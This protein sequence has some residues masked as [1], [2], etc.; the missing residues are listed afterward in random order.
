M[1][2]G[3]E[4][5]S[6]TLLLPRMTAAGIVSAQILAE[7]PWG[8]SFLRPEALFGLDLPPLVNGVLFSLAANIACYISCSLGRGPTPIQRLPS[9]LFAPP[10][11]SPILRPIAPGFRLRPAPA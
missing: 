5:W 8:A 4:V 6:Y 2:E 10:T 11:P 7:G 9:D 3:I 1:S